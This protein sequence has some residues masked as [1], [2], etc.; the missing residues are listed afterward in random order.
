[1]GRGKR[2][3]AAQQPGAEYFEF[4]VE[5]IQARRYPLWG[6]QSLWVSVAPG[7][8]IN[9]KAAEFIRYVLS[10]EGQE[11]IMADGK[12]LPLPAEAVAGELNKLARLEQ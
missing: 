5:N 12:Y 9:P 6:D 7:K 10:R 4:T 2:L 1:R 11:Q 3:P 8:K